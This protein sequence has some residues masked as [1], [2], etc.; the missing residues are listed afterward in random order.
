MNLEIF[1]QRRIEQAQQSIQYREQCHT[2]RQPKIACY[3]SHISPFDPEIKFVILIHPIEE[4][5]RIA[6]GRMSHL[7]LKKSEL[8]SGQ[9]FSHHPRVNEIL[10]DP[11]FSAVILYPGKN[12]ID[13]S[14]KENNQTVFQSGKKPVVF[15]I[16]GTWATARK[17][18]RSSENLQSLPRICFTPPK[19]SQFRVRKQPNPQ[20]YSTLE[21]IHYSL[22]LLSDD[23]GFCIENREHDNLLNVFNYMVEKQIQFLKNS[24]EHPRE[25][26]YRRPQKKIHF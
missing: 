19:P 17:M 6:T 5:R 25:N 1:Q 23:V 4:R 21:A 3:C 26:T 20:C 13:I 12:S 11:A 22:E 2:C 14:L 15:V 9:S 8:I 7:T 24:F 10:N 18:L 16:D